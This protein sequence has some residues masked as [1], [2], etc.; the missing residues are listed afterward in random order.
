MIN[1][2]DKFLVLIVMVF[3]LL[4]IN[5]FS[6]SRKKDEISEEVNN[7]NYIGKFVFDESKYKH[8]TLDIEDE[9]YDMYSP[10]SSTAY[11]YGPSIIKHEDE[12]YEALFSSPGNLRDEWDYIRYRESD[13]GL[14]WY[15]EQIVLKPTR[16]SEDCCSTCDPGL[17]YFN[18]YYYLGY[19]STSARSLNGYDNSV[20]V[21]RSESIDGPYEKWNGESWGGSPVPII[22]FEGEDKYWGYGEPSFVVKDDKLYIYYSAYIDVGSI[23]YVATADLS[24]NW[25]NTIT[26]SQIAF[27]KIYGQDSSEVVYVEDADMFLSLSI[28]DRLNEGSFVC[29]FE[30]KD[31]IKFDFVE[32][33]YG[34]MPYAHS[35]GISKDKNGHVN[36]E[37]DLLIG[38]AYGETWGRWATRMHNVKLRVYH[39][40]AGEHD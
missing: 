7:Y 26:D 37:E 33:I 16:N 30:S 8:I 39:G 27:N 3:M 4:C 12:T 32:R 1:K 22:R 20:F 35:I 14:Y 36:S 34:I 2:Q 10:T 18:G 23:T 17:I 15:N 13:D 29:L 38:Y 9:G 25:P 19:T 28:G 6:H 24:E 11:R 5:T 40:E 21:A 31:G